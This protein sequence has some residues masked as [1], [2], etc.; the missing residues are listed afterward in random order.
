[1]SNGCIS[2]EK[3]LI[4]LLAFLCGSVYINPKSQWIFFDVTFWVSKLISDKWFNIWTQHWLA[5]AF[6]KHQP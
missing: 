4:E 2:S 6:L 3:L 1:M 5:D